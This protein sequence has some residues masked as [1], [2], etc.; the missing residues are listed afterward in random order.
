MVLDGVVGA[1][2]QHLGHFGPLVAVGGVR[3]EQDPLLV[4]HPLDLEDAGVEVVV[5][6]FAA[7]LAQPPLHELGDEGPPLRPVLLHQFPHQVVLLLRPGLLPQESRPV[8]VRLRH[9][10]VVIVLRLLL[11]VALLHHVQT[12]KF[13]NNGGELYPA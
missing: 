8:V 4:R 6:A 11:L 9:R 2:G 5:P 7:L 3:E 1:S 12:H 10:V 13:K